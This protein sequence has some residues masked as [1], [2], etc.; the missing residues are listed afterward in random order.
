MKLKFYAFF[1]LCLALIFSAT[2]ATAQNIA[3]GKP[4]VASSTENIF[5]SE[6]LVVDGLGTGSSVNSSGS[7]VQD[8]CTRWSSA[9]GLPD[10]QWIYVDLGGIYSITQ[11]NLYWEIARAVNYEIQ[12]SN[13]AAVW[14]T[15]QTVTGN[16][17]SI[18]TFPIT[19]NA[20][21]V[22]MQGLTRTLPAFGYSI[23]EF[24]VYGTLV[25]LA[26]NLSDFSAT[27]INQAVELVWN[28]SLDRA[29]EF[30]VERSTNG[31]DFSQIGT[32]NPASG[33]N[34]LKTYQFQDQRPLSGTAYYR[35]K[36]TEAGGSTKYSKIISV[37]F[38]I[39]SELTV[40]PNPLKGNTIN[41]DLAKPVN[42]DIDISLINTYGVTVMKQKMHVTNQRQFQLF[43]NVSLPAGNYLLQVATGKLV[44]QTK[45]VITR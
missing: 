43:K 28:A 15:V 4:V 38:A 16:A 39:N 20:R 13:D 10:P 19:T 8:P 9:Y 41:I 27:K 36:Y 12:V 5:F 11:V 37:N 29:S 22:R 44:K 25:P 1:P 24:E 21:Y 6:T 26:I 35:L 32:I 7:C 45:L 18:N 31:V 23:Y 40:Y 2:T 33:T 42:G 34:G 30:Q 3:L 17:S 14:T